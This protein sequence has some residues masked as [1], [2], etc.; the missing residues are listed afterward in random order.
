M[1]D[2]DINEAAIIVVREYFRTDDYD[3]NFFQLV[4]NVLSI[5]NGE[6]ISSNEEKIEE[7]PKRVEIRENPFKN[8]KI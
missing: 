1:S 5:F 6:E 2:L 4:E 7:S 3:E 8:F